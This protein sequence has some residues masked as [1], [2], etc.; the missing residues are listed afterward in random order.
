MAQCRAQGV[1]NYRVIN[2][3]E[4]IDILAHISDQKYVD[5]IVTGAV[6]RWKSGWGRRKQ[7]AA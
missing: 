5:T 7:V 2:K 1:K 6:I 4:M 3:K